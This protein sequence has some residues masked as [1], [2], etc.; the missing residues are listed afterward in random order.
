MLPIIFVIFA[1]L[2]LRFGPC[3]PKSAPEFRCFQP[4]SQSYP[5]VCPPKAARPP[6][7]PTAP[8]HTSPHSIPRSRTST[9]T[10]AL[11]KNIDL[12][13]LSSVSTDS[14]YTHAKS[15]CLYI[16]THYVQ[17]NLISIRMTDLTGHSFTP[18]KKCCSYPCFFYTN[19]IPK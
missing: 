11:R 8:K 12:Y 6:V 4:K 15:R 1:R 10:Q 14:A 13:T 5:Y 16:R 17:K 9:S 19:Q 3:K 7:P 18:N 2:A